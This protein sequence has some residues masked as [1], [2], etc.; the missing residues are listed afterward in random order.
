LCAIDAHL[1][2]PDTPPIVN[3]QKNSPQLVT[4]A[5]RL[6]PS[7]IDDATFVA[8]T[9]TVLGTT[10]PASRKIKPN[11]RFLSLMNLDS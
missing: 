4:K 7:V 2:L 5:I 10:G 3:P 6:K 9:S 11:K 1:L 8:T